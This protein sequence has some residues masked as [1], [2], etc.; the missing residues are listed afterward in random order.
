MLAAST[1]HPQLRPLLTGLP[2]AAL[3]GTLAERFDESAGA[4]GWVRAK[5]GS[6]RG[7]T[8]LAGTVQDADGRLLVFAVLADA[9]PATTAAR[10]AVD[11]VAAALV[12]CGCR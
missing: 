1:D 5:T 8:S 12:A 7:V 3:S 11:S 2:V 10:D 6:L 4:A 9:V